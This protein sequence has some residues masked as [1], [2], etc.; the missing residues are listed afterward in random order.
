MRILYYSDHYTWNNM[1]TKRSIHEELKAQG[2]EVQWQERKS[3]ADA[4][5]QIIEFEPDQI[6]LVHTGLK[7]PYK[8]KKLTNH[9]GIPIVGVGMSDPYIMNSRKGV[10]FD[11]QALNPKG[12]VC[13]YDVYVTNYYELFYAFGD[14]YP[15]VYNKTACD[16]RYHEILG[17]EKTIPMSLL[18]RSYHPRFMD[19]HLRE[20]IVKDLR[21]KHK[22]SVY[23]N[24]WD[25][26]IEDN[27]ASITGNAFLRV[28]NR[29]HLG[30][31]LQDYFAP[32]AHRMFEYGGCGVPVITAR[33][34]EV[35]ECFKDGEEILT[36]IYEAELHEK[37]DYYMSHL[38]ELEQIGKNAL[39][40]CKK[41]HDISHRIPILLQNISQ[42]LGETFNND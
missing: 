1:G 11:L 29:T 25:Q 9:R 36:Y 2:H 31:D 5:Q 23:S 16:F 42:A 20:R 21:K 40:R 35:L 6:W 41:E 8:A 28:I 17:L 26:E 15:I 33:R 27:N 37:I 24:T 3:I 19:P 12:L 22:V 30:L 32:L 18:G 13:D 14:K 39:E 4:E 7:L 34:P 10:Y 38:D